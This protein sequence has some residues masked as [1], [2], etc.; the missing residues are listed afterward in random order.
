MA[1][2]AD[3]ASDL[4]QRE[5]DAILA[6]RKAPKGEPA[7]RQCAAAI[8]PHRQALGAVRCL[9]CQTAFEFRARVRA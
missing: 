2:D 7:C 5:L 3:L 9:D 6:A 8:E 1:D 4:S